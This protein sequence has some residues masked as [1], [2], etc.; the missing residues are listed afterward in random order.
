MIAKQSDELFLC[1]DSPCYP[2]TCLE[3]P[4][5]QGDFIAFGLQM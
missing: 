1:K 4:V 5:E 2:D 3:G